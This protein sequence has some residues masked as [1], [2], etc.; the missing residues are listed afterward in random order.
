ME[1]TGSILPVSSWGSPNVPREPQWSTGWELFQSFPRIPTL[2]LRKTSW[3]SSPEQPL[4]T[5]STPQAPDAT[6]SLK[7]HKVPPISHPDAPGSSYSHSV[8]DPDEDAAVPELGQLPEGLGAHICAVHLQ[9][10]WDAQ[11]GE[12]STIPCCPGSGARH[13]STCACSTGTVSKASR[14]TPTHPGAAGMRLPQDLPQPRSL[15]GAGP[16]AGTSRSWRGGSV[17]QASRAAA[18]APC[19]GILRLAGHCPDLQRGRS[20][21]HPTHSLQQ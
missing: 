8:D 1:Q 7:G 12:A 11:K 5:Q 6:G 2:Q 18:L 4:Q 20:N 17:T 9:T 3:V 16:G 21:E 19:R 14:Q 13:P 15:P 10:G